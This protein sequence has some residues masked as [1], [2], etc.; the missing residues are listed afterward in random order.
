VTE[1]VSNTEIQRLWREVL[2]TTGADN[3][4]FFSAGGH[5]FLILELL[6]RLE[7]ELGVAV[8]ISEFMATPTLTFLTE[9]AG[10]PT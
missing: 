6:G 7:S 10:A 3:L 4:D 5:S 8:D 2:G 1:K 9:R